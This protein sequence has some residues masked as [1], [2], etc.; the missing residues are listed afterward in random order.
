METN[1][2]GRSRFDG[3]S[4]EESKGGGA[5][6]APE[7]ER[8]TIVNMKGSPEYSAWLEEIPRKTHIPKVQIFRVAVADWAM[9]NGHSMPPEI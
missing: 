9:K 8:E 5:S 1:H 2:G 6:A 3:T 4:E 7:A